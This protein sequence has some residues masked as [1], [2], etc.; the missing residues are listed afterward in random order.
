VFNLSRDQVKAI[1]RRLSIHCQEQRVK[2][3]WAQDRRP[4][5]YDSKKN[6][7]IE[8]TLH[9]EVVKS[10][11]NLYDCCPTT[12]RGAVAVLTHETALK[13]RSQSI[14]FVA[15]ATETDHRS[16]E[17]R[18]RFVDYPRRE[19]LH[20]VG[21]ELFDEVDVLARQG[22]TRQRLLQK[23]F[24]KLHDATSHLIFFALM[25]LGFLDPEQGGIENFMR[26]DLSRINPEGGLKAGH[27]LAASFPMLLHGARLQLLGQAGDIQVPDAEIGL[28]QSIWGAR[29]TMSVGIFSRN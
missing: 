4:V 13:D 21:K 26:F 16:M 3:P 11:L 20:G 10:N 15:Q 2:N 17:E 14:R 8:Y 5:D 27:P 24:I 9:G 1:I 19:A 6:S 25:E 23:G 7:P 28:I 22:I 18:F 12:S 29:D